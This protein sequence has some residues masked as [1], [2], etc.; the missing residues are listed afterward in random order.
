MAIFPTLSTGAVVQYPLTWNTGQSA[1]V[2]RFLDGTDQ[3]YVTHAKMLRSW[4]IQ[5]DLLNEDEI[6]QLEAFFVAQQ[7]D[8]STF[9]FPD[10]YTGASVP[11]CR[12]GEAGLISEYLGVDSAATAFWVIETNG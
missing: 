8:Y 3:R 12:F 1:K 9:A 7:G 4:R 6:H 2:I 5:L 10:P 11:N